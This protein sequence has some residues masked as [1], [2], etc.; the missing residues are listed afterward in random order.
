MKDVR[1]IIKVSNR[2]NI[3]YIVIDA[4]GKSMNQKPVS[5]SE[6]AFLIFKAYCQKGNVDI[7][8]LRKDFPCKEIN[9]YYYDRYLQHLFYDFN[10]DVKIDSQNNNGYGNVIPEGNTWDFYGDDDHLLPCTSGRIRNVKMWRKAD[11]DRLVEW[12]EKYGIKVISA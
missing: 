1:R 9:T 4:N 3:R 8:Q 6:S 12:A 2:D 5:K 11:F 10:T 7:D